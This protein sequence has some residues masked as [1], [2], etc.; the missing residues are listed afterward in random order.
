[1]MTTMLMTVTSKVACSDVFAACFDFIFIAVCGLLIGLF[2]CIFTSQLRRAQYN[3][4]H[5][6]EKLISFICCV[7]SDIYSVHVDHRVPYNIDIVHSDHY[8]TPLI[9]F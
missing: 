1:M 4:V 9:S 7:C 5:R 6:R 8:Q 3:N 2:G